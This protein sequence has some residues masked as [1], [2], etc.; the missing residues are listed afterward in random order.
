MIVVF[1]CMWTRE[2]ISVFLLLLNELLNFWYAIEISVDENCVFLLPLC[3]DV[4]FI[5]RICLHFNYIEQ[6]FHF[7][8][9]DVDANVLELVINNGLKRETER[10]WVILS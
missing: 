2:V 4:R 3:V 6:K 9:D 10:K 5:I 1:F 7:Q 8:S